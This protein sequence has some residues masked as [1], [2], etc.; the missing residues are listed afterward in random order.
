MY[1]L[2][3]ALNGSKVTDRMS[4]VCQDYYSC[5]YIV[6]LQLFAL[7]Q[8]AGECGIDA[9][10]QGS[11]PDILMGT[12]MGCFLCDGCAGKVWLRSE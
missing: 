7:Q 10:G 11:A 4:P 8:H 1:L 12:L 2:R 5:H 3:V 6:D 9:S